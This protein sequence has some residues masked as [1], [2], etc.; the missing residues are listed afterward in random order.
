[1]QNEPEFAGRKRQAR[2]AARSGDRP[3]HR[4]SGDSAAGESLGP[5]QTLWNVGEVAAYLRVPESSVYKMT[6]RKAT[7]CIP[8]IRIG[9]RLRF[10]RTDVDRWLALLSISNL[11]SL[12]RTRQRMTQVIH[13]N[14]SQTEASGR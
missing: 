6:A 5:P 9:G 14:D 1:M 2:R 3:A 4:P 8:H 11:A 13:G 10:L 7:L 12:E